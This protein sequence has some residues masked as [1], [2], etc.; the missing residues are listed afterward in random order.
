[1]IALARGQAAEAAQRPVVVVELVGDEFHF[2]GEGVHPSAR[3]GSDHFPFR[4]R[5]GGAVDGGRAAGSGLEGKG[6]VSAAK[7]G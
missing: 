5:P 4:E 7:R 1:M 2:H 3:T 6:F